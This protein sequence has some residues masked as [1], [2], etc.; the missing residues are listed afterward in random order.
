MVDP[1]GGALE[2]RDRDDLTG[3]DFHQDDCTALSLEEGQLLSEV[4]LYDTLNIHIEG[5]VDTDTIDRGLA[6]GLLVA[7]HIIEG[8]LLAQFPPQEVIV[9]K[10]QPKAAFGQSSLGTV[11]DMPNRTVGERTEGI[12]AA[13][14]VLGVDEF[15]EESL[16]IPIRASLLH[17]KGLSLLEGAVLNVGHV[18]RIDDTVARLRLEA[19]TP[20]LFELRLGKLTLGEVKGSIHQLCQRVQPS[21]ILGTE[22]EDTLALG[23]LLTISILRRKSTTQGLQSLVTEVKK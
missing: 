23:L 9:A 19:L 6:D 16:L 4:T 20:T 14:L 21:F 10:L 11:I 13:T 3:S 7:T 2:V 5:R 17:D 18:C 12:D 8:E 1:R 22:L 15:A